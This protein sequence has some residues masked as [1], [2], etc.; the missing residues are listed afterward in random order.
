LAGGQNEKQELRIALQKVEAECNAARYA[1]VEHD[2]LS[3][4][5]A[6]IQWQL[7]AA[8]NRALRWEV[9]SETHSAEL[10]E[11]VQKSKLERETLER[12]YNE[13]QEMW[14]QKTLHMEH[15]LRS[16]LQNYTFELLEAKRELAQ[17]NAA[18]IEEHVLR[19]ST[20]RP[21]NHDR[22]ME[23]NPAA[24]VSSSSS[25]SSSS[26]S[27]KRKLEWQLVS[28]DPSER[29]RAKTVLDLL[30]KD[31]WCQYGD[32]LLQQEQNLLE[33]KS[34]WQHLLQLC[35]NLPEHII[36]KVE[37]RYREFQK[38][39]MHYHK[40]RKEDQPS[41][42]S[43]DSWSLIVMHYLPN[44]LRFMTQE[45]CVQRHQQFEPPQHHAPPA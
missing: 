40:W 38:Q 3:H 23:T 30:A 29:K 33:C 45:A 15:M 27:E 20:A 42:A 5:L 21:P 31:R 43:M 18:A 41:S 26:E 37:M 2:Q 44:A 35:L 28:Q 12:G 34:K 14:N 13:A 25:I 7:E 17:A 36:R 16:E 6:S 39:Y 4:D 11:A 1:S 8:E 10:C 22:P 24:T 9:A 19:S 32:K